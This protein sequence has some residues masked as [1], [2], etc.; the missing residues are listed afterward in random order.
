MWL[1]FKITVFYLI[2]LYKNIYFCDGKGEY[3]VAGIPVSHDP[4]EIIII[5]FNHQCLK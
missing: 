2:I 1:P 4:P 5:L 3:S